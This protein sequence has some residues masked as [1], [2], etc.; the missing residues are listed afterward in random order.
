MA[1]G[2]EDPVLAH[3]E[4]IPSCIESH[5]NVD[6]K[7]L[8]LLTHHTESI[9]EYTFILQSRSY[10]WSTTV[11]RRQPVVELKALQKPFLNGIVSLSQLLAK[12]EGIE[13]IYP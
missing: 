7:I 4:R 8:T 10:F 13:S 9:N 11:P 12:I 2:K 1:S 3:T 5:E 6:G